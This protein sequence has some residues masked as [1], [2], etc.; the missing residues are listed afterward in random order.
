MQHFK[1]TGASLGEWPGA[2]AGSQGGRAEAEVLLR[3]SQ[4]SGHQPCRD[5][6]GHARP[7]LGAQRP[8]WGVGVLWEPNGFRGSSPGPGEECRGRAGAPW[9]P[10][11]CFGKTVLLF[12]SQ[13]ASARTRA[14]FRASREPRPRDAFTLPRP[15]RKCALNS[16][17]RGRGASFHAVLW[18]VGNR[19]AFSVAIPLPR[20]LTLG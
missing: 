10:D 18:T 1:S 20:S 4:S 14:A 3:P 12:Q 16:E 6:H 7:V 2:S 13:D 8:G 9:D 19:A 17:A 15:S 11:P 5:T